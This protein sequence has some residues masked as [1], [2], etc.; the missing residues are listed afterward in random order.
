MVCLLKRRIT[1]AM[2]RAMRWQTITD[3]RV[4]AAWSQQW[5]SATYFRCEPVHVS[6]V[7]YFMGEGARSA[8]EGGADMCPKTTKALHSFRKVGLLWCRVSLSL[9]DKGGVRAARR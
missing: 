5:Q 9:H 4:A 1:S 7:S 6:Y 3:R 8:G 2:R